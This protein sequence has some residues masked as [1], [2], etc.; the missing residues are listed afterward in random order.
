V[1]LENA[2][3]ISHHEGRW[4]RLIKSL[5]LELIYKENLK[6]WQKSMEQILG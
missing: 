6:D 3:Q 4:Q 5:A 1:S 2:V